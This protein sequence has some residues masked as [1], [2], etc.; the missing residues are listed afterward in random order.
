MT[1]TP[2]PAKSKRHER[3]D[4]MIEAPTHDTYKQPGKLSSPTLCGGCNA[5]YQDGRWQWL[6]APDDAAEALC[7]ACMRTRDDYPA[8]H[9]TLTGEFLTAHRDEIVATIENVA[10]QQKKLH[11]LKRIMRTQ[12]ETDSLLITTTDLHLARDIGEAVR[13]AYKGELEL[14]YASE[15]L[16]RVRWHR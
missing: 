6:Q 9:V 4:R 5:V 14:D 12:T 10:A 1:K 13:S 15:G 2:H 7:P 8:G 11:P 3:R 16:V